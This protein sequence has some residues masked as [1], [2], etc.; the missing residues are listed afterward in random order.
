M[1]TECSADLFGFARVEGRED[2][3]GIRCRTSPPISARC[4]THQPIERA[5]VKG[6]GEGGPCGAPSI[7]AECSGGRLF[8]M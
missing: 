2:G 5:R 8:L 1:Q 4:R 3:S 6:I 7:Q